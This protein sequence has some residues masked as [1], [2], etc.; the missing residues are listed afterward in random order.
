MQNTCASCRHFNVCGL[1]TTFNS[2]V[3][4]FEGCFNTTEEFRNKF[5]ELISE[6]CCYFEEMEE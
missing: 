5:W 6:Y 2:K 1:Y 3:N 4:F